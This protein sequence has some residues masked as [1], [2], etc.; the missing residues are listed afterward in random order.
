MEH[1]NKWWEYTLNN[2]KWLPPILFFSILM[3]G[4][5]LFLRWNDRDQFKKYKQA[6]PSLSARGKERRRIKAAEKAI[7]LAFKEAVGEKEMSRADANY[8]RHRMGHELGLTG[9]LPLHSRVGRKLWPPKEHYLKQQIQ[10][11]LNKKTAEKE[12]VKQA[13]AQAPSKERRK[14]IK[15]VLASSK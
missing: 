5:L 4:I 10:L 1:W 2:H 11:R 9:L 12:A 13:R 14:Q 8:W 15:L 3:V 6:T 7:D